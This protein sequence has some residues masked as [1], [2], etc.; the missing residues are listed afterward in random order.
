MKL[1]IAALV[2]SMF[3]L[4]SV[5]IE[6]VREVETTVVNEVV[7]TT[8]AIDQTLFKGILSKFP[9]ADKEVVK[10][11]LVSEVYTDFP[12][13]IDILAVVSNESGFRRCPTDGSGSF[14]PMQVNIRYHEMD[15]ALVCDPELN[16]HEGTRILRSYFKLFGSE[17]A[18]LLAYNSGPGNYRKGNY[19]EGYYEKFLRVRNSLREL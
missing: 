17:R 2:F 11:A 12:N 3:V 6:P 13:R 18:A 8:Y 16:I 7:K 19:N 1:N 14:G 10:Q 5:V 4:V 9:N 15:P